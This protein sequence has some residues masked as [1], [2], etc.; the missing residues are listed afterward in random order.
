MLLNILIIIFPAERK[1]VGIIWGFHLTSI[2]LAIVVGA[3]GLHLVRGKPEPNIWL[4]FGCYSILMVPLI[5]L[6]AATGMET[7]RLRSDWLPLISV[8]VIIF[9]IISIVIPFLF[10][11]RILKWLIEKPVSVKATPLQ[12]LKLYGMFWLLTP[13]MAGLGLYL[14]GGSKDLVYYF[15]GISYLAIGCWWAWWKYHYSK[16]A[17]VA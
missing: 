4:E 2:G 16:A 6:R 11:D 9:S 14:L 3:L 1:V 13:S 10:G 12:T 5:F 7:L 15:A 17:N 8:V